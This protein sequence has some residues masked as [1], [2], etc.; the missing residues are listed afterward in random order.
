[1][2]DDSIGAELQA[3]RPKNEKMRGNSSFFMKK[4]LQAMLVDGI[5]VL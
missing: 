3:A 2:A 5:E 1:V 4:P